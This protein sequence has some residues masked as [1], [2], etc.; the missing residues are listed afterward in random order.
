MTSRV[1]TVGLC[2]L[3]VGCASGATG[4]DAWQADLA[5]RGG[6][7]IAGGATHI[8]L[9]SF[10]LGKWACDQHDGDIA[11]GTSRTADG[12]TDGW[13]SWR[14]ENGDYLLAEVTCAT[15]YP[16]GNTWVPVMGWAFDGPVVATNLDGFEGQTA[17]FG[18]LDEG[19]Y[20]A[21]TDEWVDAITDLFVIPTSWSATAWCPVPPPVGHPHHPRPNTI[22]VF[23]D[24]P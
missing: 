22:K 19:L 16:D 10:S 12:A 14:C 8:G 15:Y 4:P 6:R 24:G 18:P 13:V 7:P 2:L 20:D 1:V 11:F 23:F 5:A 9:Y 21:E 17:I 3:S